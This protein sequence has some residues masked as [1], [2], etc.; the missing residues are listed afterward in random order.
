MIKNFTSFKNIQNI[1]FRE[2]IVRVMV[3]V[4]VRVRVSF[5]VRISISF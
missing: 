4:N 5:R 2:F 1:L 3:K